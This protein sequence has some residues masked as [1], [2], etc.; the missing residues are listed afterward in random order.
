MPF[1]SRAQQKWGNSAAG[2]AAL[3]GQAKVNEWNQA[4]AGTALPEKVTPKKKHPNLPSH[5]HRVT[6]K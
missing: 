4:T 3:G 5:I 6:T 1:L 2:K